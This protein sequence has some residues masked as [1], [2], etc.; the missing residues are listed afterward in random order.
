MIEP[1]RTDAPD[2]TSSSWN[3]TGEGSES[4]DPKLI[5][6]PDGNQLLKLAPDSPALKAG[7]GT[8]GGK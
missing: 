6:E 3:P 2:T 7:K 4:A 8:P 1:L 5:R